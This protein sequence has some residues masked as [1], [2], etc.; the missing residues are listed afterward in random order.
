MVEIVNISAGGDIHREVDLEAVRDAVDLALVDYHDTVSRLLLRYEEDG[1]LFILFRTGKFI[2]RGGDSYEG[3][4]EAR[5]TFYEILEDYGVIDSTEGIDFNI[6]N[7]VCVGDL[8]QELDLS[9]L[10]V[11]LGLDYTEYEPEQFP[12][13]IYRP[14]DCD[15]T[16]NI[17]GTGKLTITGSRTVE[18]AEDAMDRLRERITD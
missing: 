13:L 10:A 18:E 7:V 6:E 17:Y 14:P 9:D 11:V 8:N 15:P 3:C 2:L 4:Y 5:D 16:M 12:G 1:P